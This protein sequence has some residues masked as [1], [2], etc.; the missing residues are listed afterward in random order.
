MHYLN[1][2]SGVREAPV[3]EVP[4]INIGDRQDRR[5]SNPNIINLG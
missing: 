5:T 2:S 3:F 1:S 4:V